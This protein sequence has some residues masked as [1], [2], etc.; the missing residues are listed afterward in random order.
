[1]DR[2]AKGIAQGDAWV[3]LA[4][5]VAALAGVEQALPPAG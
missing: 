5:F 4:G 2:E 1:V 3:S